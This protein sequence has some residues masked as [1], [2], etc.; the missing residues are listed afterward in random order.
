MKKMLWL[1][2]CVPQDKFMLDTE[3]EHER[4]KGEA[5]EWELESEKWADGE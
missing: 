5:A 2:P 4:E 3:T 1:W